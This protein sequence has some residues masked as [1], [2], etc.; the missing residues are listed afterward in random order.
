MTT[1][2]RLKSLAQQLA[3]LSA[4]L[5][6][7]PEHFI[8]CN[9]EFTNLAQASTKLLGSIQSPSMYINSMIT[10]MAHFTALRLFI[11]WGVFD[12]IPSQDFISLENLAKKVNVDVQLI[13]RFSRILVAQG[14]LKQD[15]TKSLAHTTISKMFIRESPMH[16]LIRMGYDMHLK[17]CSYIVSFFE[18]YGAKEPQGRLETVFAF[19]SGDPDLTVWEHLNQNPE[20]MK[21]FM[22]SMV[23]M[24]QRLSI[25]GSY[26]FS[27]VLSPKYQER[28][29]IVDVG[30]GK[31]HALQAIYDVTPGLPMDRCVVQDL[32]V[33]VI[34]SK[35]VAEYPL[36]AL[37]YYIRR[38]LHDYG[39]PDCV[40]IL[41]HIRRSMAGDSRLI[42]AEQ[43]LSDQPS[44]V[45][46][47]TDIYMLTLGG[48]ERT[49]DGFRAITADAGL[50]IVEIHDSGDDDL[51][52]IECR[53]F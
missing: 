31:G 42:I 29:L 45:A 40:E 2:D 6:D 38:C 19:A 4:E 25:T 15:G 30:G 52:L 12:A 41:Q 14:A 35:K 9:D 49:L 10:Q 37:I 34:E 48:K 50:E 27:W 46:S 7:N 39:D 22:V 13:T 8:A 44:L 5:Q 16:S 20:T 24:S 18:K 23:A 47:A 26:D 21:N 1:A 32:D 17:S 51:A 33:V 11:E 36:R 53:K 28:T 3:E 43:I